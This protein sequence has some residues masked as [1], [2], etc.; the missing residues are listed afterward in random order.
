[1]NVAIASRKS[2]KNAHNL[3]EH[4][5]LAPCSLLYLIHVQLHISAELRVLKRVLGFS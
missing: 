2:N 4:H 5:F 1:M 3:R